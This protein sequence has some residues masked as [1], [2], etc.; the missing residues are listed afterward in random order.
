MQLVPNIWLTTS[1]VI[2]KI[3]GSD[4]IKAGSLPVEGRGSHIKMCLSLGE[5]NSDCGEPRQHLLW[6]KV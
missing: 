5:R 4:R 2:S 3:S 1:K 6:P